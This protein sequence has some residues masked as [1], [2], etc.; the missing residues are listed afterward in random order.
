MFKRFLGTLP[1]RNASSEAPSEPEEYE[2][3]DPRRILFSLPTLCEVT[4]ELDTV[5]APAGAR[6]LHEDDWRQI[7]FVPHRNLT[8]LDRELSALAAFTKRHRKGAGWS[9]IHLRKEH[10]TP[11]AW[12]ALHLTSLPELTRSPLAVN[13][14]TVQ[15]GFA[16]HDGGPWFLY[17]QSTPGGDVQQLGISPAPAAPSA[18]FAAAVSHIARTADCLVIDW[19][20][21][22]S[23]DAA[24]PESVLR[25]AA[26]R[27]AINHS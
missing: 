10:P 9:Q 22:V 5:P 14:R 18:R 25:W 1:P 17:G 21:A 19:Y 4:P 16:L 13:G 15:D 26:S 3:L 11:L 7:E 12:R 23:V 20:A 6:V 2:L 27:N 24:S 8:Y